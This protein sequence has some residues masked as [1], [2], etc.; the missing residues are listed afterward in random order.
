MTKP[1]LSVADEKSLNMIYKVLGTNKKEDIF[2]M[3][4][5]EIFDKLKA[6]YPNINTMSG[7]LSTITKMYQNKYWII[8]REK[9][10]EDNDDCRYWNDKIKEYRDLRNDHNNQQKLDGL[11]KDKWRPLNEIIKLRYI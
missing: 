5:N 6:K 7:L 11:E 1:E 9:T 10:I 2:K 3:E 4:N 8:N